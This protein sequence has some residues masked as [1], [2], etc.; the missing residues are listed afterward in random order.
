M[1]LNDQEKHLIRKSWRL[2]EQAALMDTATELFYKDLF[3]DHP[4]YRD[5]FPTD[6]SGQI[7][8]LAKTLNFAV[9]SLDWDSGDWASGEMDKESDLFFI[10][11]AMGR[12]HTKLY[13]VTNDQYDPVGK[14]LLTALDLGLG[15]AFTPE[16]KAAWTKLYGLI[17]QTML[18]GAVML[19]PE[20]RA[21]TRRPRP[22]TQGVTA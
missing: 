3:T 18:L 4:E 1:I 13:R 22:N 2:V 19:T 16:T 21:M 20:E 11:T 7:S 14:S 10:L 9:K 17:A 5:Q 12:R 8:K 6:M 15:H